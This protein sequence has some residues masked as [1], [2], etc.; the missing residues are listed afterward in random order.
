[1]K[2]GFKGQA[3]TDLSKLVTSLQ[4]SLPKIVKIQ[5]GTGKRVATMAAGVV[6]A[7]VEVKDVALSAG[8]KAAACIATGISATA[9]ASVSV[10]VNIKASASVG[11]SVGGGGAAKGGT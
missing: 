6:K 5:L 3:S 8:G 4:I 7:G 11:G 2:I 9:S 10:D 1:M